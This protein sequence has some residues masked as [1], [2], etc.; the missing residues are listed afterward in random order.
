MPGIEFREVARSL[1]AETFA[2]RE[3]RMRGNRARCP[4][5]SSPSRY[6]LAFYPDGRCYCYSCHTLGDVVSLAST[7]WNVNQQEAAQMLNAEYRLGLD[8]TDA[9]T[10]EALRRQRD[11][12]RQQR[13]TEAREAREAWCRW[14]DAEREAQAA[15]ERFTASDADK[16]EFLETLTRLCRAQTTLDAMA[17]D[18]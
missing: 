10:V 7:V 12:E 2:R 17:A 16:P 11:R 18:W 4:W 3:L 6:N 1:S 5:C 9:S 14:C 8:A 15:I 13:E